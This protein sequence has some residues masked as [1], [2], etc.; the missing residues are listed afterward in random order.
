MSRQPLLDF[1]GFMELRI[2]DHDGEVGKEQQFWAEGELMRKKSKM[3][4]DKGEKQSGRG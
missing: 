3:G 4:I 2:I 1:L